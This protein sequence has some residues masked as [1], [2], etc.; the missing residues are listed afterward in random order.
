[1]RRKAIKLD[2]DV[3]AQLRHHHLF[4]RRPIDQFAQMPRAWAIFV[5]R[6]NRETGRSDSGDDLRHYIL[7]KRKA[8]KWFRFDGAY[9][10][11]AC[12]GEDALTPA[13]WDS[14]RE[15]YR[16]INVGRDQYAM[17]ADL[18]DQ[19]SEKFAERTGR[20][21][22]GDLLYAAAMARQK[23]ADWVRVTPPSTE[24]GIGFGDIDEVA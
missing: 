7:T 4:S 6:W 3:D 21:V 13:E 22:S 5:S 11:L 19:L 24:P 8:G 15:A 1:M 12:P 20:F 16:E 2:P 23:Q 10:P 18:R 9:D 17:D 14:L